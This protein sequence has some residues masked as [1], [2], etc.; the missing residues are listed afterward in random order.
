MGIRDFF[1]SKEQSQAPEEER[2][3]LPN[4]V[5]GIYDLDDV[6][7]G[8]MAG[9]SARQDLS[10]GDPLFFRLSLPPFTTSKD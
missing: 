5:S 10:L 7:L 9:T 3:L 6:V 2:P 8:T 1:A 4:D